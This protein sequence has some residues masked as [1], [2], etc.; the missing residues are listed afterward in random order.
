VRDET[1]RACGCGPFTPERF[2]QKYRDG[3]CRPLKVLAFDSAPSK[4]AVERTFG[5]SDRPDLTAIAARHLPAI[6]GNG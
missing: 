1:E 2:N 3:A 6:A 4:R 5:I